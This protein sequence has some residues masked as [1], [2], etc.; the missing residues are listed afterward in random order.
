MLQFWAIQFKGPARNERG[1][2][3][4]TSGQKFF[5]SCNI[6]LFGVQREFLVDSGKNFSASS[7]VSLSPGKLSEF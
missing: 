3:F 7:Q 6:S 2:D 4:D 1:H 5:V